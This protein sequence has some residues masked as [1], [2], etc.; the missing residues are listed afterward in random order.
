MKTDSAFS[1]S[2]FRSLDDIELVGLLVHDPIGRID[3]VEFFY[4]EYGEVLMA[5]AIAVVH[6]ATGRCR[7]DDYDELASLVVES[8]AELLEYGARPHPTFLAVANR[9]PG[10]EL[11]LLPYVKQI[12]RNKIRQGWRQRMRHEKFAQMLTDESPDANII[13]P[14]FENRSDLERIRSMITDLHLS[15]GERTVA[16]V[17]LENF[18]DRPDF[19][20][21]REALPDRSEKGVRNAEARFMSKLKE[22]LGS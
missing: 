9:A 2:H 8:I 11:I 12:V 10:V 7:P 20:M 15:S 6:E 5:V 17:Y 22:G 3:V 16:D 14:D 18:P 13:Y 1:M 21:L 4:R 19:Q